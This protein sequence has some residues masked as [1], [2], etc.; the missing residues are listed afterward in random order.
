MSDSVLKDLN[1]AQSAELEKPKDSSAKSCITKPVLNENAPPACPDA[2]TNGCEAGNADVEYIDSENLTDLPDAGA[3]LGTLVA[4]LDSKDWVMTCE[5]LNNVRQLAIY[6]KDRLQE[7]LEPLVPL[8]VKSVKNPRSAVCKTALMTC[9]DIFKAYGDLMV[10]SIDPLLVQLFLKSSQDKR[11]VCEAAEAALIS[12]TSW[13]APSAL[14]PK[15]QPYLK[16]RNPRIRAKASMCF[17]KSVPH[18]VVEGIK[19][20]GMDKL[21]QIAATQLSDQLPES[22]EAARKLALELQ[23]FYEKSQASSSGEVDDDTPATSPDAESWEAFCQSK[24]SA[25]SAQAILRVTS[26]TR[27]GV[28]VGVTSTTTKEGVTVGC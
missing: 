22:R 17:S 25:L 28:A 18:F 5:A 2:V 26:T 20:Y 12:M 15:V 9:A 13:I 3:T 23:A 14:L 8:I 16:N 7:L 27:E 19:E 11:F 4:R 10:D 1:L 24:L 6:H 21:V